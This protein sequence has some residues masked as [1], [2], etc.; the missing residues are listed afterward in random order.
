MPKTKYDPELRL[1]EHGARLYEIWK[2]VRKSP[3][4]PIF[5][6]Y[7]AFYKWAM[8]AGYTLG[9]RLCRRDDN[10]PYSPDNC[11]WKITQETDTITPEWARAFCAR[12]DRAVNKLRRQHGLP[13]LKGGK[14]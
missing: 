2:K 12:W 3:Y 11:F 7:D 1:S 14:S 6:E 5:Q 10:L 13:P 9:N 8:G 4:D